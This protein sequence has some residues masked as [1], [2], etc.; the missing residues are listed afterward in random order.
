MAKIKRSDLIGGAGGDPASQHPADV[1]ESPDFAEPSQE[2]P[3][4]PV[5]EAAAS[6]DI[7]PPSSP[8]VA[9]AR[10]PRDTTIR[11][12]AL[13]LAGVTAIGLC[14]AATVL[15]LVAT[16]GEQPAAPVTTGPPVA[17]PP[18]APTPATEPEQPA[19]LFLSNYIAVNPEVKPDAI[20]IDIHTDY[21]CP[22]CAREEVIYGQALIELSQSG[23]IDLRLH[24]RSLIG[25][26]SGL[27]AMAAACSDE[28]GDFIAYHSFI[29]ANQPPDHGNYTVAQLRDEF[30]VGSGM[31]G[32]TLTDFQTCFDTQ[33][34][35][36][37]VSAIE[38]EGLSADIKST[39]AFFVDGI[40]VSFDLQPDAS[41]P[42]STD[43][44]TLLANLKRV[45]GR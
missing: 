21:Q 13:L 30:A 27:A 44:A 23:D 5:D 37:R 10:D 39:P 22:W 17:D 26:T 2:A 12:L 16:P 41:T 40:Q 31:T 32:K 4:D 28:V 8:M 9:P 42:Q 24:V 18:P 7:E 38:Q 3:A 15:V 33:A 25:E 45:S 14:L 34:T 11:V 35:A 19:P 20:V 6:Q 29:F 43:A 1:P 36:G